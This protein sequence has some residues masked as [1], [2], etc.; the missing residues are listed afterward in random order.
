MR[1]LRTSDKQI[2]VNPVVVVTDVVVRDSSKNHNITWP[3]DFR[4]SLLTSLWVIALK[5]CYCHV[6]V[7]TSPFLS[8]VLFISWLDLFCSKYMFSFEFF[9]SNDPP[10][11]D[12][13]L[14][15]SVSMLPGFFCEYNVPSDFHLSVIQ[16]NLTLFIYRQ[17]IAEVISS[18]FHIE[19]V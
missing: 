13:Y 6:E 2:L 5:P 19:Q 11:D 3:H 4:E 7:L 1:R 17:I 18:H 14:W 15:V 10:C 8:L 12:G 9:I 16:F